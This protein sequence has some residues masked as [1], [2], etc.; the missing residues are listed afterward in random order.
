M[1]P[2]V[3]RHHRALREAPEDSE[4]GWHAGLLR[5]GREE[6][7]CEPVARFEGFAVREPDLADDV[8]VSA[9]GRERQ[10]APRRR[11]DEAPLGV[12]EVEQR[13][14]VVLVGAASVEED[15]RALG[16]SRRGAKPGLEAH[17]AAAVSR[18]FGS[19]VRIGSTCERRCSKAGGSE[20]RSPRCSSGSSVA[21]PGPMVAISKRT[22]LGSRK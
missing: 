9:A 21:N 10:R 18:G 11:R 17:R 7:A 8:P 2:D 3:V 14:E 16:F 22:P 4:L 5:E 6:F 19:G 20:R 1:E 15:E 12:E 13:I